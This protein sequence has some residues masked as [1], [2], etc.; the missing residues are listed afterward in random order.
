MR[1]LIAAF[2][3]ALTLA[4]G[5]AHAQQTSPAARAV[6]TQARNATGGGAWNQLRG[7]H[8]TGKL[9][10]V[11]YRAWYDP[12]RY[13]ARIETD[14]PGGTRV[15]GFNGAGDWQILPDRTI[16]ASD[17]PSALAQARTAAYF[18]AFGYLYPSRFAAHTAHL[19][20]RKGVTGRSYAVVRV[21]PMGGEPRELWFDAGTH[22]LARIVDRTGGRQVV[23]ELSDY[24]RVG[25]LKLPFR[26]VTD[27]GGHI[28][29]R[30]AETIELA[31]ADRA[32]FSWTPQDGTYIP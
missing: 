21:E 19:G 32:K 31:P 23:T 7:L 18:A 10:G 12:I 16:R 9:D 20:V 14:E 22:L 15:H 27:R 29:V 5:A 1:K 17:A 30:Q 28:S 25:D 3:A 6:I 2:A 4:G 11:P 24:R 13:G 8:E 26:A